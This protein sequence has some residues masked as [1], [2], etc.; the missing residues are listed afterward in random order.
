MD[1]EQYTKE[2]GI[3]KPQLAEM[4]GICRTSIYKY[5]TLR[6]AFH[7]AA[8]LVKT[9]RG[10]IDYESLGWTKDGKKLPYPK[11]QSKQPPR[12]PDICRM[13]GD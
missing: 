5:K 6:P 9:T 10:K 13:S 8:Q 3:K 7:V 4:L 1:I 11:K 12:S 2:T